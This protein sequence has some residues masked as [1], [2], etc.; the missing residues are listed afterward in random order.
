MIPAMAIITS[1]ARPQLRG[2][3]M[4]LNGTVQSL[5]M[6]LATTLSGF[7]IVVDDQSRVQGYAGV[8]YVAVLA[9]VAAIVFVSR[10]AMHDTMARS[11]R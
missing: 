8:A 1:A 9:N 10:I 5:A 4:S 2:T 11:P 3:F 6:G 7:M